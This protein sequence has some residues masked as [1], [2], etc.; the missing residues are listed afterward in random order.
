MKWIFTQHQLYLEAFAAA[1]LSVST[2][3]WAVQ[4]EGSHSY[5]P[6]RKSGDMPRGNVKGSIHPVVSSESTHGTRGLGAMADRDGKSALVAAARFPD[7]QGIYGRN[8]EEK[9]NIVTCCNKLKEI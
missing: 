2:A 5:L 6:N 8:P 1:G 9:T 7:A 3:A 4:E